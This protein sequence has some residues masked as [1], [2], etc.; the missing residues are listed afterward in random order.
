MRREDFRKSPVHD[1]HLAE[2]ADHDVGRL[3]VAM[4]DAAGVGVGHRLAH[5]LEG[6]DEPPAVGRRVGP[7]PQQLLESFPLDE[8]HGQIRPAVGQGAEV[9]DGGDVR[10]LEQAGDP[11]LVDE[12]A[13]GVGILGEPILEHL[14]GDLAAEGGVGGQE[15]DA[16]PAAGDLVPEDVAARGRRRRD[17]R[18][19]GGGLNQRVGNL[20]VVHRA[21]PLPVGSI[22]ALSP[23]TVRAIPRD[24]DGP[25]PRFR[26]RTTPLSGGG[27]ARGA[28][29]LRKRTCDPGLLRRLM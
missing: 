14:D 11:R 27:A 29:H 7:R 10:V 13:G 20:G 9:V 8:L 21:H 16:H 28:T 12:P 4:H 22:A 19:A 6:G 23:P 18:G 1:L 24:R 2:R 17:G 3:E 26:R 15:Y 25:R 5:L